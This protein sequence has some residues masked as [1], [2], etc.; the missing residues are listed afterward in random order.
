MRRSLGEKG[1]IVI[2]KDVRNYL[3]LKPGSEVILEVRGRELIVK[4]GEDPEKFVEEFVAVPKKLEK[5]DVKTLKKVL[6]E[7]YEVH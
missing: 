7:E 6:E 1:Q 5:L 2:P 3:G 4:P